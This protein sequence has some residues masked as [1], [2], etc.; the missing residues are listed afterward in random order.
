VN[1][2][3]GGSKQIRES[4]G[5]HL[6]GESLD[7]AAAEVAREGSFYTPV[8]GSRESGFKARPVSYGMKLAGL[9]AGGRMRAANF[10]AAQSGVSA[11]AADLGDRETRVV[12]VNKD[13]T[14]D[15]QV[16]ID[17]R[18]S[19]KV[20]RLEAP[21]LTAT[22]DVTLAGSVITAHG[23]KPTREDRIESHDGSANVVVKA[24]SA[25]ALFF[26]HRL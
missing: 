25:A 22:A 15:V 11:Y 4:L 8:A 10:D 21:N 19:V 13:E 26:E 1:L 14:S 17:C 16:C 7:P 23:W 12:V 2:H 24:A 5:G 9:L 18:R 20:W 3:G 6:P